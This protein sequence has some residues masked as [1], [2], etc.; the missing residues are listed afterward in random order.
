MA[1]KSDPIGKALAEALGIP[2][3]LVYRVRLDVTAGGVLQAEIDFYP[4][5]TE[6]QLAII[7]A[8]LREQKTIVSVAIK[9][10]E[11]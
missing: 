11:Q 8:A 7:T 5:M 2:P 1:M 10:F 6:E 3:E 4:A 9:P